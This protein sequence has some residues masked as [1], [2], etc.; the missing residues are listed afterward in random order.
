M[1]QKQ[2][3]LMH[4]DTWL[5]M[6]DHDKFIYSPNINSSIKFH[7]IDLKK[8][9]ELVHL[10]ITLEAFLKRIT[11]RKPI[12]IPVAG[13]NAKQLDIDIET[14]FDATNYLVIEPGVIVGYSRNKKTE[15]ALKK[16]GVKV[17]AFK[18]NQLSLGM[19]SARCMS[20]PL[21]RNDI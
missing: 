12:L 8:P 7:K 6:I 3:N 21:K 4:L 9:D 2:K 19:G 10:K 15:E 5:T 13:K 18:G 11:K 1:F 20:M 14:H 17:L 16:A